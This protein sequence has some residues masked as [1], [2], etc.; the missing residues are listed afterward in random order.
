VSVPLALAIAVLSGAPAAGAPDASARGND[1]P[2]VWY[3]VG[4]PFY[5]PE[6]SLGLGVG[7]GA[8]PSLCG[9]CATSS[10]DLRVAYTA[11]RQLVAEASTRL[12][13]SERSAIEGHAK[14]A[15]FPEVFYGVGPDTR[16]GGEAYTPRVIDATL[17]PQAILVPRRMRLGATMHFY[18]QQITTRQ[19]GALLDSGSVDGAADVLAVGAGATVTW[20]DR[21]SPFF[22][23]AG[24]IATASYLWYPAG[25]G[26]HGSFGRALADVRRYVPLGP[27]HTIALEVHAEHANGPTP[28]AL[29]P[30]LGSDAILR[31]YMSARY[32]DAS[33]W[34]AQA[35]Y[36]FP[37]SGRFGG[38]VFGGAGEVAR[39][40]SA[41]ALRNVRAA[42][43]V[44]ARFRLTED[45][46]NLRLDV[47]TTGRAVL[48]YFIVLE[49]F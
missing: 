44:G 42:G 32:R 33:L 5:L 31:G 39:A 10:V 11:R 16:G 40:P 13:P 21:D 18:H 8:H 47:A 26:H 37:V 17:S 45:G 43:G 29:L 38:A 30:Y 9:G 2:A 14:Y 46:V 20:D 6:T 34:A 12:F 49:A 28:F 41:F 36:R 22:P 4:L 48:A 25:F 7:G 35:E 27:R 23:A 24:G 19:S 3:A 1:E 15:L